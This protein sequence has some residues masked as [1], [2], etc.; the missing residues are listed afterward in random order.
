M[1]GGGVCFV[2]FSFLF[3][4]VLFCFV[5]FFNAS[6]QFASVD[7]L[8]AIKTKCFLMF[9]FNKKPSLISHICLARQRETAM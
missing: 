2:L 9:H 7:G 4:F 6:K 1:G 3:C 5:F 8:A